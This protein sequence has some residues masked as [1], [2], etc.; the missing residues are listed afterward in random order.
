MAAG[1]ADGV[2]QLSDLELLHGRDAPP[3][4]PFE[5]RAGPLVAALDGIELRWIRLGETEVLHG[6]YAAIRDDGW[7]T[8]P[9]EVM[10]IE[11]EIGDTGFLVQFEARS[12]QGPIDITWGGRIE[13]NASGTIVFSF[14][15][16]ARSTFQ[17]CRIGLNV[18]HP[19]SAAGR[20]FHGQSPEGPVSGLLPT[21]LEPPPVV[22]G[23]YYGLFPA[24]SSLSVEVADGVDVLTAFEGDLF[25]MEDQRNWTDASFKTYSTPLALGVPLAATPGKRFAQAVRLSVHAARPPARR[26]ITSPV[27]IELGELLERRLPALGLGL[28]D[29]LAPPTP[30]EREL[31][32]AL[33]LDHVRTDLHPGENGWHGRLEAATVYACALDTKLELALHLPTD[34]EV[35]S[36]E[37]LTALTEA[38]LARI[39]VLAEGC[40]TTPGELVN[41]V[42]DTLRELGVECPVGG[43]TDAFF[44]DLNME[45]PD[46]DAMDFVGYS[47]TPQVHAFDDASIMETASIQGLTVQTARAWSGSRPIAVTAVSLRMRHNPY[48]I[49]ESSTG[50]GEL[51]ASVDHRQASL[52]CAAWS[53][54]SLASLAYAGAGSV[55]YFET[56][57][58]RGVLEHE[59]GSPNPDLFRSEPATTFP[60]YHALAAVADCR[61][62]ALVA[63]YSSAAD[64]RVSSLAVQMENALRV[65][66]VNL[67]PR[68]QTAELARLPC[69]AVAART[70]DVAAARTMMRRAP[71]VT[72][73]ADVVNGRLTLELPPYAVGVVEAEL[74]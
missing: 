25:E 58:W 44:A 50:A 37:A 64:S 73:P 6:I 22:D 8:L 38:P 10:S 1:P 7:G 39:L 24:V 53:L 30:S 49:S 48:A 59:L 14:E 20:P 28:P 72:T 41:A 40:L 56:V 35:S 23:V 3:E 16:C 45:Q 27:S 33:A 19:A 61:A 2:T 65:L 69:R 74:P 54:A 18:L 29:D 26:A 12:R 42:R 51:P 31:L 71:T 32:A 11:R 13:G 60:V 62:G 15:G 43:G 66:V 36:G 4:D 63:C 21:H 52:L 68:R 17:Y 34:A 5:L 57:G 46:Q 70:L 47:I 55:T 67:T 9:V